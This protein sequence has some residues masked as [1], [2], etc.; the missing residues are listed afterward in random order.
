MNKD[1]KRYIK[2]IMLMAAV[3]LGF[4]S[5]EDYPDAFV[6]ADG[7][8]TVHY[9]RYA[10]N[11][12]LIDKAYMGEIICFVGD[13][14]CSVH[15]LWFN[16]QKALLNTSF[17]TENTLIVAIPNKLAEVKTNKAYMITKDNKDTVAVDFEVMLPAPVI[18]GMSC[19]FQPAGE[20][21]TLYGN[22]FVEPLTIEFANTTVT[23]IKSVTMEEMTFVIP[24]G[25]VPGKIKVT[26]ETGV[27]QSA[28]KYM[29]DRG[30]MFDFDDDGDDA[31][32]TNA[33]NLWHAREILSE[34]GV[35]GSYVQLGD[36]VTTL[37]ENADWNDGLY[38]FEFW[39][40]SWDNPQN[41]T[42]GPGI[43]LYNLADLSKPST[44]SFKFEMCIPESNPW[45]A[46]AMQ[47]CFQPVSQVTVSGNPIDGEKKVAGAN[48]YAFNNEQNDLGS[49]GRALYR[50]WEATGEYHTGGKWITVT[51][52]V[53]DFNKSY[54][55]GTAT[56][57]P[58]AEKDFASLTMFV[59]GGGV[60][61]AECAPVIKIDN[62]RVV[63][64]K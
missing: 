3:A 15:E 54:V 41:I 33:S 14:L 42:S 64:N 25:T 60:T 20:E 61:G 26:T 50:P 43:A 17:M 40:G 2:S 31:L 29:E 34:G 18:K 55:N 56:S 13:N 7:V 8:P 45:K 1:M 47:I 21:V 52:P 12:Q 44:V 51:I 11:D 35:D 49:W 27:S 30:I 16:D 38:A 59:L 48:A 63:P 4:S 53:T 28:F 19:E 39:C 9:V 22:Y 32:A 36:G 58:S 5:C 23:D 6:L 24:E 37:N 57:S 46:G 10:D 62:I